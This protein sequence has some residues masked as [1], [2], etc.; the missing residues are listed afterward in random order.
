MS[1][2]SNKAIVRRFVDE[3]RNKGNLQALEELVV[4]ERVAAFRETASGLLSA[5][6]DYH[7]TIEDLIAE[8]DKVVLR[9]T[10]RGTHTGEWRGIPP[11]GREVRWPVIRVF[12]IVD[13]KIVN[14]WSG[15]DHIGL[16]EQMG[17][18]IVP[19]SK[20]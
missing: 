8:D 14:T 19:G 13:G 18:R 9:A 12:H 2:E 11:S 4:P 16:L 5:F 15:S 10:Q 17:G 6:S 3:V 20:T 7:V 1:L